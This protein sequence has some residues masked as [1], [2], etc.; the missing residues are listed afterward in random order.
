M[1]WFL[2][3]NI[4]TIPLT[5][6]EISAEEEMDAEESGSMEDLECGQQDYDFMKENLLLFYSKNGEV[7]RLGGTLLPME[8]NAL[9]GFSVWPFPHVASYRTPPLRTDV[10]RL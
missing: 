6:L 4:Y 7:K 5:A 10:V 9:R 1:Y 3:R 2:S 8:R